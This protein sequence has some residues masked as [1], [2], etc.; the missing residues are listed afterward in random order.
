MARGN[1]HGRR[2]SQPELRSRPTRMRLARYAALCQEAGLVPV[3]E[4]EVLMDGAHT[5]ERCGVVTEEAPADGF[6]PT[7]HTRSDAGGRDS[8][9]QHGPSRIDLPQAGN[10]GRGRRRHGAL[11]LAIGARCRSGNCVPVGRPIRG[12]GFGTFE[13]HERAIR[14]AIALGVGVFI[15][16]RHPA[17]GTGDLARAGGQRLRGAGS[18]A[19]SSA[20]ATGPRA[21]ANIAPGMEDYLHAKPVG[22]LCQ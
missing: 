14:V 15:C 1:R 20:G 19:S 4:P 22:A 16:P 11:S 17:T 12:T 6:Q 18:F 9:A 13:C 3:V 7:V 8:E 2:H 10:G 5:L 21:A